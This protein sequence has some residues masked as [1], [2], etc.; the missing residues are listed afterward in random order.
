MNTG[1]QGAQNLVGKL[2]LTVKSE[3]PT[4]Y[5]ALLD[6]Y[7][8][9]RQPIAQRVATNSLHSMSNHSNIMD[10]RKTSMRCISTLTPRTPSTLQKG[11]L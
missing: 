4:K 8:E 6:T 10:R 7:Q 2:A 5:D 9:E 11:M 3:P 1:I